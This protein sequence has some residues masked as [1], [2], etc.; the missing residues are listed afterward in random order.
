[1]HQNRDGQYRQSLL[2][3]STGGSSEQAGGQPE[4]RSVSERH[5]AIA[6]RLWAGALPFRWDFL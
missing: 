5:P 1:M 3:A 2:T 6:S 4:G